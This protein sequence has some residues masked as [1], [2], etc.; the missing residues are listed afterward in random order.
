MDEGQEDEQGW[1]HQCY[2]V[3]LREAYHV[4]GLFWPAAVLRHNILAL[5]DTQH[6]IDHYE[7]RK[8]G[9]VL[10]SQGPPGSAPRAGQVEATWRSH[11]G[12][13]GAYGGEPLNAVAAHMLERPI[14][15]IIGTTA[16]VQM[17]LYT[18][19]DAG[20]P[21]GRHYVVLRRHGGFWYLPSVRGQWAE[22]PRDTLIMAYHGWHYTAVARVGSASGQTGQSTAARATTP[23]EAGDPGG[24]EEG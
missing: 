8:Y 9:R 20:T 7:S 22:I 12:R 14:L 4:G 23:S 17:R 11:P 21:H 16:S 3:A 2:F 6:W 24:R 1:T 18:L 5:L 19:A 13:P 10:V 15:L